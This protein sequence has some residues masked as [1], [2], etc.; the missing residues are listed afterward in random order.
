MSLIDPVCK[1][2]DVIQAESNLLISHHTGALLS[3]L[4][5]QMAAET[6][7]MNVVIVV[8]IANEQAPRLSS[9]NIFL[10]N[11]ASIRTQ[12]MRLAAAASGIS[13]YIVGGRWLEEHWPG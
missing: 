8:Q 10:D 7:I 11:E 13:A 5:I 1:S 9:R 2:L 4:S 3:V 12:A 6:P